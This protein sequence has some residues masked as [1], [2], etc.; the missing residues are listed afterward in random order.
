MTRAAKPIARRHV[1][2]DHLL[3]ERADGDRKHARLL[4]ELAREAD[5][6]L[7]AKRGGPPTAGGDERRLRGLPCVARGV[8]GASPGTRPG[9][10]LDEVDVRPAG[11]A[12]IRPV[13]RRLIEKVCTE[14]ELEALNLRLLNLTPR[15]I[16]LAAGVSRRAIEK[17]L[18]SALQKIR[19]ELEASGGLVGLTDVG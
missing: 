5:Q 7:P 17:R 18:R 15:Q 4:A 14:K 3:L 16:G 8:E 19:A 12:T 6:C 10:G 2:S 13:L 9:D 1:G 11:L